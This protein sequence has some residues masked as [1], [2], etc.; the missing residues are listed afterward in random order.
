MADEVIE[1]EGKPAPEQEAVVIDEKRE[2]A[3][4][5]KIDRHIVPFLVGLYLFSFL[6]RVNIGNAR[7]YGL[8]EDLGLKGNQYQIA[9]SILFIPYCQRQ[10]LEV[11]SNLFIRRFTASRYISVI[12]TIWGLVATL[13]GITQNF[14][15]MVVCRFI[16][17][18]VEAGLFPGLIAYMTLFYGKREIALRVGYLFSAAAAAGACGGLLAYAIGFL[19]GTAGLK[20]WRWIMILEGI[21]S[22]LIGIATWFGLADDP[23]TAYYLTEEEKEIGRARRRREIGQTDSAQLFHVADAKEGA[24]DWTIYLFCLGQFG[25]DAV[26]Y[27]YSTFLPTII[28]AFG[29]WTG[30]QVQALTIPC[31]ALGAITYLIIAWFSD[32]WQKRAV[33]T[34]AFTCV[35]ILGYGLL[36]SDTS[37]GVHYFGCFLV[38][39]GVYVAVGLPTAWLPTNLPRFG[40]RA[41]ATGLQLTLGNTS[42]IVTPFLYPHHTAP[43]YVMGHAVTLAL[44]GLSVLIYGFMW[45][46]YSRINKARAEGKEDYKI[47]G[48]THEEVQEMGDRNPQFRYST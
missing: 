27:G 16:L 5:A 12:T 23:D 21:P 35:T 13:S 46:H 37:S 32:R 19:D 3:L 39:C 9:V 43:R 42:G 7:L 33:F 44:A 20:G 36:I 17:G 29:D 41:F 8:E 26:L 34:I 15:G 45:F 31:Y 2:K 11:P 28:K 47:E 24:K 40:K 38:A 10:L 30:P 48:M 1:L 18:A 22:F 4:I 14:A 6:D 25:T